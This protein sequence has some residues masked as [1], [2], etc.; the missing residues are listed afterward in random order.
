MI[1]RSIRQK[2]L[3]MIQQASSPANN[4]CMYESGERL[5]NYLEWENGKKSKIYH[6]GL[7]EI[8]LPNTNKGGRLTIVSI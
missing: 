1:I 8:T 5:S 6:E 2:L 3:S 7:L 4:S